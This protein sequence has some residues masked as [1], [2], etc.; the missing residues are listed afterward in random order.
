MLIVQFFEICELFLSTFYTLSHFLLNWF[1][2]LKLSYK[3]VD[4]VHGD[5]HCKHHIVY[6]PGIP[7]CLWDRVESKY[8]L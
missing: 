4:E 6:C 3:T 1:C 7:L 2:R 5:G 8:S